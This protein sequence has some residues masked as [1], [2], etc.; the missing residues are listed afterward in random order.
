LVV[1][2][3]YRTRTCASEMRHGLIDVVFTAHGV[4]ADTH[5]QRMAKACKEPA[6]V[7]TA[8]FLEQLSVF[9]SGCT[10]LTPNELKILIRQSR[11]K[12]I[13][14]IHRST[15]TGKELKTKLYLDAISEQ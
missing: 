11:E 9:G 15:L 5:I 13:A 12:H 8:D 1:F 3:G 2:D 10:R 4:T 6:M 7:V 14:L